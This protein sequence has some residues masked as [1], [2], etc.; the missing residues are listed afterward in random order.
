MQALE[1]TAVRL[2]KQASSARTANKVLGKHNRWYKLQAQKAGTTLR[3]HKHVW[4][5][6]TTTRHRRHSTAGR[7]LEAVER[8]E[9]ALQAGIARKQ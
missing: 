2:G 4:L 3:H 6:D 9:D 7:L 1:G 5:A 8:Q